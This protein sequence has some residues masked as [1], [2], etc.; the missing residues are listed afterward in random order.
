MSLTDIGISGLLTAQK[1][2]AVT[3]NN[4]ANV[5]TQGYS[6]QEVQLSSISTNFPG[7]ASAGSGVLVTDVR[8]LANSFLIGQLRDSTSLYNQKSTSAQYMNQIDSYLGNES[9]VITKGLDKFFAAANAA[10][11]DPVSLAARQQVISEAVSLSQRF[12]TVQEQLDSQSRLLSV[13]VETATSEASAYIQGVAGYNKQIQEAL[14]NGSTPNDLMDK[15][16]KTI[17][18]LA[19]LTG[20]TVLPQPDGMVNVYL[21]SGHPLVLGTQTNA[22]KVGNHPV[23]PN[24]AGLFLETS[25]STIPLAGNLGGAIGGLQDYQTSV[26]PQVQNEVGRLALVFSDNVNKLL[27][28]GYDLDGHQGEATS[29]LMN[30]VN[31]LPANNRVSSDVSN[32]GNARF[33]V[34]VSDMSALTGDTFEVRYD[35]TNFTLHDDTGASI[36][37]PW[38][39]LDSQTFQ[40][41]EFAVHDASFSAGDS[42]QISFPLSGVP[43]ADRVLAAEGDATLLVAV[44]DSSKL[45]ATNYVLR[46]DGS[47]YQITRE[48]DGK[49]VVPWASVP[50]GPNNDLQGFDGLD[51]SLNKGALNN[52]DIYLIQPSRRAADEI[53]V[54][55]D[56]ARALAFAEIPDSAGDNKQLQKLVD[57][58]N[59]GLVSDGVV[60]GSVVDGGVSLGEGYT[61]L[62]GRVAVMTS[63]VKTELDTSQSL[64]E[65]T[66]DARDGFS[67][68]NLD[69]EAMNLVRAE[70]AYAA[71]AQI[72]SVAQ[73]TFDTLLRLF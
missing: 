49:V 2:M 22:L 44:D 19:A 38:M 15:R 37:G 29:Q 10:S 67:G 12:N 64:F 20:I 32:A 4:I 18:D 60:N 23:D 69:E 30:D 14:S 66:R 40:G 26:L 42:F 56:N 34:N 45:Q 21:Q 3:S 51:I 72:I 71:S 73:S 47:N 7:S 63:Q 13:Q 46:V 65:Q 68:V 53:G 17:Q 8:R 54:A 36:A 16:E 9:S 43:A 1:T 41:L 52:G 35:G 24:I 39:S 70:Q 59:A 27:G 57:L 6:R 50:A 5:N 62:V 58:Q 55:V 61:R 11:V 28:Q 33:S 31:W 25:N 48:S